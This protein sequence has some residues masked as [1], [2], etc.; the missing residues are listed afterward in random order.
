MSAGADV[1]QTLMGP[2]NGDW[3]RWFLVFASNE[4]VIAYSPKS[5]YAGQFDQARDGAIPWYQV[6]EPPGIRFGRNDPNLDPLGYYA[7][8]ISHLVDGYYQ[9]PG[10]GERLFG[11]DTNPAQVISPDPDMLKNGE[12]DAMFAYLDRGRGCRRAVHHVAR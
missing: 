7:V 12:L 8:F 5:K 6:L 2:E 1:N 11:D 9:E 4:V 10:L 3:E